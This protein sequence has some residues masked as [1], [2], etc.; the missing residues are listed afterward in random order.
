[1]KVF[2]IDYV[3]RKLKEAHVALKRALVLLEDEPEV[4]DVLDEVQMAQDHVETGQG[5]VKAIIE[6][7]E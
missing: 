7:K 2:E 6:G 1:M 4:G 3:S 5:Y